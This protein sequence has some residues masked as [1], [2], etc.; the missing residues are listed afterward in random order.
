MASK[1]TE[2]DGYKLT[3]LGRDFSMK[4]RTI[5]EAVALQ[6]IR[7]VMGDQTGP[8][9]LPPGPGAPGAFSSTLIPGQPGA[10]GRAKHFYSSKKPTT[11]IERVTVLAYFLTYAQDKPH[12]KTI[13][14]TKT[15]TEAAGPRLSNATYAAR[16]AVTNGLL[17]LAGKGQKQITTLGEDVVKALPDRDAVKAV[18]AATPKRKRKPT[19]KRAKKSR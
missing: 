2:S 9:P 1:R 19:A 16:N 7:L 14:L 18:L 17:A 10:A 5:P 13:D 11:D 15:N 12:F 4:N 3:L 6:V 8:N